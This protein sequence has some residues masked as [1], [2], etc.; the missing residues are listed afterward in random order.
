LVGWLWVLGVL[1]WGG[2]G[3]GGFGRLAHQS[4]TRLLWGHLRGYR[5]SSNSRPEAE[6]M[7]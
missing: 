1:G 4:A 6:V 2:V 3:G 7:C 5:V